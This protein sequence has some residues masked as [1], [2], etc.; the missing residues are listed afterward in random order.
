MNNRTRA[1]LETAVRKSQLNELLDWY[2]R[3]RPTQRVATISAP[4]ADMLAALEAASRLLHDPDAGDIDADKVTALVD[5][6]RNTT[7]TAT[8]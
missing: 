8:E 7:H 1:K 5:V 4:L 3:F 6:Q 2:E